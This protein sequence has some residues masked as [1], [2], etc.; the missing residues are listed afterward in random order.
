MEFDGRD[1]AGRRRA[2]ATPGCL[3]RGLEG[4]TGPRSSSRAASGCTAASAGGPRVGNVLVLR[5]SERDHAGLFVADSRDVTVENVDL[6]HCAGLGLLAQF[7]ENL[8][9]R[10]ASRPSRRRP[11]ASL[12]GPRRRGPRLQLPRPRPDRGVPLPRPDGRSRSTSTAPA[13]GSSG[14]RRP[15]ASCAASCTTSPRGCAGAVP[16]TGSA[17]SSTTRC[18]RSARALSSAW[19]RMTATPSR[20]SLQQPVPPGSSPATRSR[21]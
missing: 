15:T 3:G 10:A 21:T 16:A 14:G 8:T 20:C 1:P 6:H 2:R 19:R 11:G 17:S 12:S 18:A 7:S 5:H 13:C 4:T 9:V